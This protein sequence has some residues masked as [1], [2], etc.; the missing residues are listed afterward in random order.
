MFKRESFLFI[1]V[2]L[3][4]L[5][6]GVVTANDHLTNINQEIDD[7]LNYT[8]NNNLGDYEEIPSTSSNDY[9]LNSTIIENEEN[10]ENINKEPTNEKPDISNEISSTDNLPTKNS[11]IELKSE[12]N[13]QNIVKTKHIFTSIKTKDFKTYY[14]SDLFFKAK[15]LNK[16]TNKPMKGLKVTFKV[17][18]NTGKQF[19]FNSMTN[20]KGIASLNKNFKVGTYTVYTEVKD[21]NI[22]FEESK[23]KLTVKPTA[24]VGCCSFY[25]QVSSTDAVAGFRRDSTYAADLFIQPHKWYGRTAIKQH[26]N[27]QG[28]FFHSITTSDGWMM[29]TGGAD[30][31]DQNRAIEKLAGKM[32]SS[33]KISKTILYKIQAYKAQLQI[34]HFAI[35]APNGK[36]GLVWN[37]GIK[38]GKLKAGEYISV[39]NYQSYFRHGKF[40]DFDSN[41]SKAALKIGA[42]DPYGL[43]RRDITVF[44]WKAKTSNEFKTSSSVIVCASNDNGQMRGMSTGYLQDNIHFKN[45]YI[46]KYN[47]PKTPNMKIL[48]VHKFGNIDKII[49]TQT[50][51]K[52]SKVI[53]KFN[54]NKYFKVLIKDKKT[55]KPIKNVKIKIKMQFNKTT[56]TYHFKANKKGIVKFSVKKF[57][58]GTHKLK[59]MPWNNKYIISAKS[60]I[61]IKE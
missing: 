2:L 48:G 1:T 40:T 20:K 26:K 47:L 50:T 58:I 49:K 37:T 29:G 61:I 15:I 46:S 45:N 57:R 12:K 43:N 56:H 39:P 11:I 4:I 34:G 53:S 41:P 23:S 44:H 21:K 33:G 42:T 52:A 22:I 5:S 35:K 27:I 36:Y 59:I 55:N 18:S 54:K 30:Y 60:K 51:V 7:N 32:V 17:Y 24:E 25:I 6:L 31:P 9:D 3:L 28:Y 13:L 8:D 19:K 14:K 16:L 10:Y 38:I